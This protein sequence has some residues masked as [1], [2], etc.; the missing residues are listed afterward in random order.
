VAKETTV[1]ISPQVLVRELQG[2]SVLLDQESQRYFGLD[3]VGTRI[4][5]LLSEG[6]G[7]EAV[8]DRLLEEYDVE[9]SR[10]EEDLERFLAKLKDANLVTLRGRSDAETDP[11]L[12]PQAP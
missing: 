4:W 12:A 9:R 7:V 6:L 8:L 2:E 10:L 11:D 5:Q 3:E 1:E